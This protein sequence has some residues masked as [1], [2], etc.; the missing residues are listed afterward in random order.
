MWYESEW[1]R[2]STEDASRWCGDAYPILGM[3]LQEPHRQLTESL[4]V[5]CREETGLRTVAPRI[6][7][8]PGS[9]TRGAGQT[10]REQ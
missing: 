3:Q 5:L 9:V 10:V 2:S 7:R 6:E 8:C 1:E 4:P